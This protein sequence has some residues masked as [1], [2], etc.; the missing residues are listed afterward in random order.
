MKNVMGV[1]IGI[2]L[3]LQ[4]AVGGMDILAIF[5]PGLLFVGS[6]LITDSISVLVF[7]LFIFFFNFFLVQSWRTEP[8]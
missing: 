6:F 8:F 1:L 2:I 4:V 3:Y 5:D 7:G